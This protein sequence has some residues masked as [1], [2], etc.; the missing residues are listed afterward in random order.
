MKDLLVYTACRDSQV[1]IQA[2]LGRCRALGIG[3]LDYHVERCPGH[4]PGMVNKGPELVRMQ[5]K[6]HFAKAILVWDHHGSDWDLRY[7]PEQAALHM[8]HRLDT[9]TWKD[10][11]AAIVVVPELEEWLWHDP[12]ALCRHWGITPETLDL[13]IAEHP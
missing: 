2:I 8:Q 5:Y 12:A 11:S 1:T 6:G 7:S 10:A 13:W 9:C 4:D 3:A